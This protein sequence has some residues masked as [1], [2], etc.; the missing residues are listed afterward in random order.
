LRRAVRK[1]EPADIDAGLDH[2]F[3]GV[4]AAA[5]GA[6]RGDDFRVPHP[7]DHLMRLQL[8]ADALTIGAR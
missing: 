2:F 7:V 4:D 5:G 6:Y 3:D 8:P 1:I